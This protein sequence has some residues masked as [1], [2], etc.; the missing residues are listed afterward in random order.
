MNAVTR[1]LF[2][3]V[4]GLVAAVIPVGIQVGV[5]D[6]GSGENVKVLIATIGSMLGAGGAL[7]ASA[8]THKQIKAGMHDEGRGPTDIVLANIPKVLD[9]AAT[10]QA[11]VEKMRQVT[12]DLF[13]ASRVP[14]AEVGSLTQ[15]ALNRIIV[16]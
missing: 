4:T 5:L 12:D 15:Q 16:R 2:Y 3:L 7:T 13:G 1:R 6:T 8:V 11:N 9:E 14:P 10:A